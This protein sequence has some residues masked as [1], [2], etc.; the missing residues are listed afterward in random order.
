MQITDKT[1]EILD[2]FSRINSN[3]VI[4]PGNILMTV[5]EARNIMASAEVEETF[6]VTA[7]IYDLKEFVN[8]IELVDEPFLHFK[9]KHVD[10]I[11]NGGVT[12]IKY[13]YS[14][15]DMLTAPTKPLVMPEHQV[16]FELTKSALK[17]I[18][19]AA[20]ALKHGQLV[21]EGAGEKIDLSVVDPENKTS[22]SY[23][24]EVGGYYEGEFKFVLN[25]ANL[26]MHK[27]DYQVRISKQL[28]AELYDRENSVKY[29]VA[30]EKSSEY[31]ES[32]D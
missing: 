14:D 15:P 13:F 12:N 8:L 23:T 7:G 26:K 16:E 28:I 29:W 21:I 9:D 25:I 5:S 10:I 17:Q 30:L 31:K 3:L 18:G 2:G 32:E 11:G 4:K 20:Q 6:D 22:N 27:A 24:I 19:K 1:L